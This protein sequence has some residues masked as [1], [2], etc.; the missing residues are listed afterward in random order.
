MSRF[1]AMKFNNR[2]RA[3]QPTRGFLLI[4]RALRMERVAREVLACGLGP[5][6]TGNA[7]RHRLI[8]GGDEC[9]DDFDETKPPFM[10]SSQ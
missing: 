6:L 10:V 7:V 4:A 5:L 2:Q 1:G 9:V 3:V 8:I